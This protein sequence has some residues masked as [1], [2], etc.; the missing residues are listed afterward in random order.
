MHQAHWDSAGSP[1]DVD[2]FVVGHAQDEAGPTGCTVVLCPGGAVG[3][4]SVAGAAPGTRGMDGLYPGRLVR[5][6]HGVVFTGGSAFGLGA[7]DGVLAHLMGQGVGA[8]VGQA[9]IP[10]VPGAVIFDLALNQGRVTPGAAMARQACQDAAAGPMARGNV[11]AGCGASVGKLHGI[12]CATKGG[13]GGASLRVGDL[14]VG[15]L[16]VVNAFG[17][18]RDSQGRVM[19]GARTAPDADTLTGATR[20]LLAGGQRPPSQP[21]QN[22]TLVLVATNA[23]LDKAGA[24]QAAFLAHHGLVRSIDPVHTLMDGDL[25]VVLASGQVEADVN[26]LGV[27]AA[28]LAEMAVRDAVAAATP[29]AGLPCSAQLHPLR[30][31]EEGC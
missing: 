15:V 2:G 23:R 29:L 1:A 5:E 4:V 12:E 25:S 6:V 17:D 18:I 31:R 9:R 28:R 13:L 27:M 19:A 3:G 24:C 11:G 30:D 8:A 20:W 10:I 26:G 22:T 16:A 21:A 7:V 14:S